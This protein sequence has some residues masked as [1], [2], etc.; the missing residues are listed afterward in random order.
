MNGDSGNE[1]TSDGGIVPDGG[2]YT[3][4]PDGGI[5]DTGAGCAL[6]PSAGESAIMVLAVV[7]ALLFVRRLRG[8]RS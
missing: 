5:G 6:R 3:L 8:F 4:V 2:A 7:A 1:T